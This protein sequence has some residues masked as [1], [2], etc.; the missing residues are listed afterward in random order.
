MNWRRIEFSWKKEKEILEQK[1]YSYR[2]SGCIENV[3]RTGFVALQA[4]QIIYRATN[5][6]KNPPVAFG[7][8][9]ETY[10]LSYVPM[11]FRRDRKPMPNLP[12][13]FLL[14]LSLSFRV[15]NL[16]EESFQRE[17]VIF[18][19]ELRRILCLYTWDSF[20]SV[21]GSGEQIKPKF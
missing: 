7:F 18:I 21:F 5:W 17:W 15:F 19:Y 1:D 3:W 6:N 16:F 2:D 12:S 8:S 4:L 14:P 20:C 10:D 13:D 9:K 11:V